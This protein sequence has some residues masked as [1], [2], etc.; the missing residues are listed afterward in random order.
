M[1]LAKAQRRGSL[2]LFPRSRSVGSSLLGSLLVFLIIIS[3]GTGAMAQQKEDTAKKITI[4]IL[5]ARVITFNKTDSGEYH[6]FID[7]V[8]FLEGTDTLYCDSA[9]QNSSTKNF[10]AFGDVRISQQDGTQGTSDYL[11]YTSDKKLAFMSGN[12]TLVDGKNR[13]KCEELLYDLGTKTGTYSKWG[14]LHS[15]STDVTSQTGVYNVHTKDA[16]FKGDV[17]ITDPR[18][19]IVSEDLGYNTETKFETFYS[20]STVTSD[21]GRTILVTTRGT[22]DSKNVIARFTGPSSIWYDG[23]YIEGDSM[24]Y[25]KITGYGYAIGNVVSIDTAHHSTLY[26]GHAVYFRKQR[27]LWAMIK[28]V[29]EQVNGKD[30]LYMRADTFYTA[31]MV[32]EVVSRKPKV[33][34]RV[35][36]VK[37]IDSALTTAIPNAKFQNSKTDSNSRVEKSKVNVDT[38]TAYREGRSLKDS[39]SKAGGVAQSKSPTWVVPAY[40]YRIPDFMT[41][42]S[43]ASPVRVSTDNSRR[44]PA[45]DAKSAKKSKKGKIKTPQLKMADTSAADTT[46]PMYFVGYNH[47]KIFSDSMQGKCDSVCYTRNDST[48]RMINTPILWAHNSQITGDTILLYLDSNQL[49]KMYVPNNAFLV[50]RSGPEQAHLYDQVQGKTLTGHFNKNEIKDMV[51]FPNAECI[52]YATDK[53]KAYIGVDE[54][55][56]TRM[57]IYFADQKITFIKFTQDAK[58][59]ITPLEKADLPNM[60]LGRFKWLLDQRPQSKEELFR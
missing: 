30:T 21:S 37:E 48:V 55:T 60:K 36:S 47:V 58:H 45:P 18:Y 59:T 8:A 26:C 54:A 46:A 5:N 2:I 19:H 51:V 43:K 28:P 41:D 13:L 4:R 32:K 31:P 25:N 27:I 16:R 20:R 10:E 40:K 1:S 56:S 38:A 44:E 29:M 23:Q 50:S 24:H 39:V 9:Y 33:I 34:S 14:T 17:L 49:R 53:D 3:A 52:Y 57:R 35:D 12:V 42:S 11:R 15:D 22:Y 7:S 6:K